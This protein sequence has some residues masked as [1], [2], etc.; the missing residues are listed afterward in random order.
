M[1]TTTGGIE[2]DFMKCWNPMYHGE[3][4]MEGNFLREKKFNRQGNLL[5]STHAYQIF[6]TFMLPLLK[7]MREE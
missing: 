4:Q 6:D 2:E 1:V 3:F 7:K 5:W